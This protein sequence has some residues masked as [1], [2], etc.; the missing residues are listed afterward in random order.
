MNQ[1]L[2]LSITLLSLVFAVIALYKQQ[3][4]RPFYIKIE[5]QYGK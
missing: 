1:A 3:T 5:V 4:D 2:I